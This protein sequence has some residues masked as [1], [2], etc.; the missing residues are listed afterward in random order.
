MA[1]AGPLPYRYV[2]VGESLSNHANA[3]QS[4]FFFFLPVSFLVLFGA[5]YVFAVT[6]FNRRAG[7]RNVL[8]PFRPR[9]FE[10]QDLWTLW[11]SYLWCAPWT[12]TVL[13]CRRKQEVNFCSTTGNRHCCLSLLVPNCWHDIV[14][15]MFVFKLDVEV[16]QDDRERTITSIYI[17]HLCALN[18]ACGLSRDY[19]VHSDSSFRS[20]LPLFF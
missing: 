8:C 19:F 10:A 20:L 17:V 11:V 3:C 4:L 6:V 15:L 18:S 5:L 14:I 16:E 9:A 2:V 12:E 13:S 1:A 7:L